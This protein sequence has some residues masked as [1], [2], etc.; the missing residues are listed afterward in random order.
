MRSPSQT[1]V[2]LAILAALLL[3]SIYTAFGVNRLKDEAKSPP[4]GATLA[5]QAKL[6]A[7]SAETNLAAQ[8]AGLSAASDLLQR[9]PASPMDAAET[10]LRAAGGEAMAVA[11]VGPTDVLAVAGHDASADWKTVART[12]GASGRSLWISGRA[13]GR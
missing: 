1:Y 12:A 4:G 7:A 9:D 13:P 3:L 6:V 11:V 8:R 2:R 5:A 10:A